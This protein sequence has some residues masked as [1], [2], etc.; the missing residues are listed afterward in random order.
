MLVFAER[1]AAM[2]VSERIVDAE[3][4]RTLSRRLSRYARDNRRYRLHLDFCQVE[5]ITAGGLGQLISLRKTVR[6]AGRHLTV[7]NVHPFVREVFT[8]VGLENFFDLR[9][10]PVVRPAR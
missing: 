3:V 6:A 8:L 10:G 4:M 7:F 9:G 2:E 5:Q 1:P